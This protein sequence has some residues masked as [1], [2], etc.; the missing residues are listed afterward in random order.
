MIN[1]NQLATLGILA[2]TIHWLIARAK[3]TERFWRFN[4]VPHP[5]IGE[6]FHDLLSCAA[7]S[8]WWIGLILGA[9]VHPIQ[10]GNAFWDWICTGLT[11]VFVTPVF[12]SV[13]LW[14]LDK[15]HID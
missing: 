12:E 2:A 11:G 13:L 1:W 9:H 10:T 6:F 4:W 3:I 7:C 15:S 8:G 14:G 5:G